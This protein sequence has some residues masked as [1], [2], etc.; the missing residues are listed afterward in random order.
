MFAAIIR[1]GWPYLAAIGAVF[2]AL[3]TAYLKGR[4]EGEAKEKAKTAQRTI[5]AKDE[6]LEMH[7]EATKAERDAA[8][9]SDE[10]ARREAMKW[11]R[12]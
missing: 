12:R 3:A 1:R 9:L 10:Q 4:G 7:R 2:G 11:A 8:A 6:Q 5:A